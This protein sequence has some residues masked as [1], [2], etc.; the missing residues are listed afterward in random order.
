MESRVAISRE[1]GECAGGE[2]QEVWDARKMEECVLGD[3]GKRERRD[4]SEGERVEV[5]SDIL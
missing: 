5:E 3:R 4:L 1:E 2:N